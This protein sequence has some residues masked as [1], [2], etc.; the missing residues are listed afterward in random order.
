MD[1]QKT[2]DRAIAMHEEVFVKMREEAAENGDDGDFMPTAIVV[3]PD[4]LHI[5]GL[6]QYSGEH[7]EVMRRI[8]RSYA[9]KEKA[10]AIVFGADGWYISNTDQKKIDVRPSEHPFKKEALTICIIWPDGTAE[11]VFKPYEMREHKV[12]WS[13]N[14]ADKTPMVEQNICEPWGP[15]SSGTVN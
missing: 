6:P 14:I 4:G 1:I 7:K 3:V 9:I 15:K 5:V 12:A 13:E 2:I 11:M 10:V 8:L